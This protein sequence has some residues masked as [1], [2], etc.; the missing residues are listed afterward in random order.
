MLSGF[1]ARTDSFHFARHLRKMCSVPP[2]STSA[3]RRAS[4]DS[5]GIVS[6]PGMTTL[7]AGVSAETILQSITLRAPDVLLDRSRLA[8][9]SGAR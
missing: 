4:V 2:V 6:I 5:Q 8:T 3:V 7:S 9:A 1:I